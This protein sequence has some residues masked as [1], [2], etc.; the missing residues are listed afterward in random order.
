MSV[1]HAPPR[2]AAGK[3]NVEAVLFYRYVTPTVCS[4]TNHRT[5]ESNAGRGGLQNV[6][7]LS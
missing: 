6:N 5:T 4:S 7:L 1:G 3:W 2:R